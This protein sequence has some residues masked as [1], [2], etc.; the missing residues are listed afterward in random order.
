[1]LVRLYD[2][3]RGAIRLD[4]HDLRAIELASLRRNVSILFQEALVLHGSVAENIA[5][6][7]PEATPGGD[8]GGGPRGRRRRVHRRAPGRLRPRHRRARS[9][10]L[11]RPA[12]ADRDRSRAARRRAGAGARRAVDRPR[13]RRRA[14]AARAAARADARADDD[15]RLARP[16]HRRDADR[17][18][19]LDAVAWSS[20]ARHDE[21][22]AAGGLYSRLWAAARHRAADRARAR[23]VA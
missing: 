21:L 11:G 19:V 16:A 14:S 10:P 9:Q 1:M 22:L 17:I 2:P 20:S 7:R 12:P 23:G 13:R 15:R 18:A 8:R 4:G 3:E 5:I 6:G